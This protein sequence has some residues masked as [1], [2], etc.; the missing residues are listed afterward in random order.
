MMLHVLLQIAL[1]LGASPAGAAGTL[2]PPGTGLPAV[3]AS[4]PTHLPGLPNMVS[5]G[6]GLVSGG[7]PTGRKAFE[8]MHGLGIRTVVSVDGAVPDL[9][10]ARQAGLRYIHLPIGYDGVDESRRHELA[11]AVRDGLDRGGVYLHCHHGKHR[12]AAAS[13]VV[14]VGLG[15]ITP[16]Q[17]LERMSVAGTS[18]RY[19][20][21]LESVSESTRLDPRRIEAVPADLPEVSRPSGLVEAMVELDRV[22]EHLERISDA[23]WRTPGAHPD[24]VPAAEA[25]RLAD[26][27]R[28]AIPSKGMMNDARLDLMRRLEVD[29][30]RASRLEA[31]LLEAEIPVEEMDDLLGLIRSSCRECHDVHRNRSS[32]SRSR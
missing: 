23:S 9:E 11:R 21:L 14:G 22:L 18:P 1:V 25:G 28:L 2:V 27:F 20:G 10:S 7:V 8:R 12:S 31:G 30:D 19:R 17:A 4:S 3:G 15:W 13:G 24:L 6:N 5:F 32:V 29:A 16:D 26:L